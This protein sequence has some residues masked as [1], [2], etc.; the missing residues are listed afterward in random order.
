MATDGGARAA[1]LVDPAGLIA[2][3]FAFGVLM[4]IGAARFLALGWVDAILVEPPLHFHY[5]GF[6][7]VRPWPAPW[8]H[9]HVAAMGVAALLMAL[10][11]WPRLMAAIFA[12]LF[13]Y[14]ELISKAA[15]LNH[16]YL[17]S[18]LA[19]LLAC[20]RLDRPVPVGAYWLL[21]AQVGVVYVFAGLAKLDADW[22]LRAEPLMTWMQAHGDVPLVGPLLI[23]PAAAYA[24]SWGG[25]LFDLLVVPGLLWRRTRRVVYGIAVGFHGAIWLLFP[26]GL[27]SFVM[28]VSATVFFAPGWPRPWL[29]AAPPTGAPRAVGKGAFALAGLWIGLQIVLP[30]RWVVHPGAVNWHEQGYRFAWRVMLTEKTGQLEY[31]ICS[32][33]LDPCARVRPGPELTPLQRKMLVTQP[34]M[35]RAYAALLAARYAAQGHAD[36]QVFADSWASLNGRPAQ[37]YVRPDVEL[38]TLS[39][40]AGPARWIVPLRSER[41]R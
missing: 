32:D 41:R 25:A 39:S 36:V 31:R 23:T 7:W 5:L 17:V 28:L 20:L 27:F 26:V 12:V 9:V 16:Y 19:V 3:R 37:R 38:S 30:L 11:R 10:G 29:R 21:R 40:W 24:M 33:R 6:E 34:D 35:I 13:T 8:M 4:A 22:L 1:R 14:A 18:L 15:Y 2:F